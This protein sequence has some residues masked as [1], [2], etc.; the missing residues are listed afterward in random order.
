MTGLVITLFL[1]G[2]FLEIYKVR[3]GSKPRF[4]FRKNDWQ[5]LL[6]GTI[7]ALIALLVWLFS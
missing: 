6:S 7:F 1:V 5:A 2:A 4:T 3:F